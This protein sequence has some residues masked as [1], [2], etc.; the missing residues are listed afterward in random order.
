M[1]RRS[2]KKAPSA[3]DKVRGLIEDHKDKKKKVLLHGKLLIRIDKATGKLL[4]KLVN[5]AGDKISLI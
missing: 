1:I 4:Y 3:S 5:F 2:L